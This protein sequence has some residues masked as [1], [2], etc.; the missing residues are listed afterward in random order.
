MNLLLFSDLFSKEAD[1]RAVPPLLGTI[2][3][4]FIIIYFIENKKIWWE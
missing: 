4:I 3:G 1:D 2:E